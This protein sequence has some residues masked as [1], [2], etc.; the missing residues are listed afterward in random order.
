MPSKELNLLG[1]TYDSNFTT[2]PYLRQLASDAK[3]RSAIIA[4]LSYSVPP[5]L[6][7]VFTNGLL[8]GK[9]MA[10]APAVI[11][12]RIDHN[13]KGANSLTD[14]INCAIKSV[15]RTIT[16][17][18]LTDKIRS[19]IILQKAGLRSLNEMVA[20]SSAVMI[21]KSKK[22]MDPLGSLIFQS[23]V[24]NQSRNIITRSDTSSAVKVPVPGNGNV[25]ANLLARTWNEAAQVQTATNL[26]AAKSAA[27]MW[28]RSLQFNS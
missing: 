5:H 9:I 25:A 14:K 1:I 22:C 28:A 10:A 19:D 24:I 26:S 6:L 20:Y 3:T 15:A 11:P 13:D 7:K 12:F 23:K 17:T 16:R 18:R 21:W 8:L 2:V 27:K 4:R